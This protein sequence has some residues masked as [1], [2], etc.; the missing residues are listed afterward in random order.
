MVKKTFFSL[1]KLDIQ[2]KIGKF[3][4]QMH[5][6]IGGEGGFGVVNYQYLLRINFI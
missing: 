6:N 3:A 4:C 2:K 1:K 5:D